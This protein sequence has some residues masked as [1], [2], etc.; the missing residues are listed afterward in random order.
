MRIQAF[1]KPISKAG[2]IDIFP[3]SFVLVYSYR[4][5]RRSEH[6]LQPDQSGGQVAA[7]A[8]PV[9]Q[10]NSLVVNTA[11]VERDNTTKRVNLQWLVSSVVRLAQS[12]RGQWQDRSCVVRVKL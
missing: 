6:I 1:Q 11:G 8:P 7:K 2:M 4:T 3:L 12:R 10:S 9:Y 5:V